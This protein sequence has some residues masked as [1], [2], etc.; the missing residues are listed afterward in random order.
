MIDEPTLL[1]LKSWFEQYVKRFESH[2]ANINTNIELKKLHTKNVCIAILDIAQSLNLNR[3]DFFCAE[4][5]ALLHDIGRFDQFVRHHTF[6]DAKSENHAILGARILSREGA[7]ADI[8]W[9]PRT[10]ILDVVS[11]HNCVELPV[12]KDERCTFFLKLLRD[13]DKIDIWRVVTEYYGRRASTPNSS[14][15]LN[16]P[17]TPEISIQIA[18]ELLAG[19]IARTKDMKTLND[20]KILQMGWVFD[21]NFPRTFEIA[22]RRDYLGLLRDALPDSDIVEQ[23]YKKA[24]AHLH[25]GCPVQ[26]CDTAEGI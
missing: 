21:L 17:D 15:E 10:L 7:L 16:L 8:D 3:Q 13:A 20:F 11:Y 1:R 12:D 26:N 9:Q 23:V 2:D 19:R 6:D 18:E 24:R 4:A 5:V 22:E 25:A 14:I